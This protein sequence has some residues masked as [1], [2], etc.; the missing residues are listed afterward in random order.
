[1][2]TLASE[3]VGF[4]LADGFSIA[5][6]LS[7]RHRIE[8]VVDPVANRE[9]DGRGRARVPRRSAYTSAMSIGARRT[10]ELQRMPCAFHDGYSR[11]IQM[12]QDPCQPSTLDLSSLSATGAVSNPGRV[13]P[14]CIRIEDKISASPPRVSPSTRKRSPTCRFSHRPAS[15][16]I[17]REKGRAPRGAQWA[18]PRG[19][20]VR[21]ILV[22]MER[23][24]RVARA[25]G[26]LGR[27]RGDS[28]PRDPLTSQNEQKREGCGVGRSIHPRWLRY[29]AVNRDRCESVMVRLACNLLSFSSDTPVSS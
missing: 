10:N 1:M 12:A 24:A 15:W 28:E 2:E 18:V 8:G 22:S 3:L 7:V 9:S 6:L 25:G 29:T 21:P 11:L 17:S 27:G 4:S 26:W 23:W 20:A 16:P 19:P 14:K 5:L 13:Y